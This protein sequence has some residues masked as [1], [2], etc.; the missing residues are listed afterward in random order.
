MVK[1]GGG[2]VGV[3]VK[4]VPILLLFVNHYKFSVDAV[5][6]SVESEVLRSSNRS[7]TVRKLA[8]ILLVGLEYRVRRTVGG[9]FSTSTHCSVV[10]AGRHIT[11]WRI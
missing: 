9:R 1:S 2:G 3:G 10:S 5:K 7:S 6:A 11:T 4:V 8:S